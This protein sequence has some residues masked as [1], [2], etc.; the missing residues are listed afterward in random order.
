MDL[1]SAVFFVGFV[2]MAVGVLLFIVESLPSRSAGSK[3]PAGWMIGIGV[4]LC[5]AGFLLLWWLAGTVGS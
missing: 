4:T 3:K 5:L 2:L 1:I